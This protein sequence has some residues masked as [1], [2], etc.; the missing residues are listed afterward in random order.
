MTAP[1]TP[2]FIADFVPTQPGRP[3]FDRRA[4][5]LLDETHDPR[6]RSWVESANDGATDFPL[7]N[8]PYGRFR[9]RGSEDPWRI[10]VAIG[11]QILDLRVAMAQCP[12]PED[13]EELLA[14]LAAGDLNAFMALGRDVWRVL[15]HALSIAL[16]EDSELGP[17]LELCLLPQSQAEMSQPCRIGEFTDFYSGIHHAVAVGRL[18]RPDSPL[19][20]NY[21][22]V[23]I[24]Y[25]GRASSIGVSG[26]RFRRPHGQ[27]KGSEDRPVYGPT[28]RLEF[29]LEL[30]VLIG[31]GSEPGEPVGM[32]QAESQLF[33][34]VLLNDW[35]ARDIQAWEYQP[36]GPFQAK[37]FATT[38][39]PWVVTM[40]ALAPFRCAFVRPPGDPEPLPHLDSAFNRSYG[41]IDIGASAWLQTKAMH[42]AGL[43]PVL[44]GASDVRGQRLLD[45]GAAGG[46]S[47][48]QRLQPAHRRPARHRHAVRARAVAGRLAGRADRRR[49]AAAALAERRDAHLPGRRRY[50]DPARRLRAHGLH[51]HRLRRSLRH[52]HRLSGSTAARRR[53]RR[54]PCAVAL[55]RS[56]LYRPPVGSVASSP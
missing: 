25:H 33:G 37:S 2:S 15:R 31:P 55:R 19:L 21:K 51:A 50:G 5:P 36:L 7:Q 9:R 45:A 43:P 17:F 14:P 42:E 27:L 44:L 11:D 53:W 22:W 20:P 4:N 34:M 48:R 49:P 32:A 29:E 18:F 8:L 54:P 56:R 30:G 13:I 47:H 3:V 38:L 46:A 23:P 1:D 12:W 52:G 40:D 28:Q 16:A 26:Q 6:L 39:S 10:G 24:A 35:S 41:A